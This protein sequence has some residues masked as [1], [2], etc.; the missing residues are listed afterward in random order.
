MQTVAFRVP[1]VI[2]L[3][4]LGAVVFAAHRRLAVSPC[5]V[6]LMP[7]PL[8]LLDTQSA[9]NLL[10]TTMVTG[11]RE[12]EQDYGYLSYQRHVVVG[13]AEVDR[14][15]WTHYSLPILQPRS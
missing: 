15:S 9:N 8:T 13:L 11:P 3:P 4:Y 2:T 10:L 1:Y 12:H 6:S 7:I 5:R 14:R